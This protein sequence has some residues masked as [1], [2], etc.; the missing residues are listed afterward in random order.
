MRFLTTLLV[1]KYK[2]NFC[3]SYVIKNLKYNEF[4]G[5]IVLPCVQ[6]LAGGEGGGGNRG[7]VT[8]F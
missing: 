4:D 2:M 5:I 3:Y 7:G 1:I 6:K 8:T